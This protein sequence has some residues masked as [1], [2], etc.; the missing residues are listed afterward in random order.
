MKEDGRYKM[1]SF[2][3]VEISSFAG[4]GY[5]VRYDFARR[6]ISW[7]DG[8]MWNNNFMKSLTPEKLDLIKDE[9]PGTGTLEWMEGYNA[10]KL[11]KYGAPTANPSSWRMCVKFDDGTDLVASH[12]KNFPKDW[13]LLRDLIEA[14]TEC[15]FRLR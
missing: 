6:L 15:R 11:A 10:G 14:T 9:L 3:E 5:K 2:L 4:G 13:I 8:Y 12:A 1:I 7:N